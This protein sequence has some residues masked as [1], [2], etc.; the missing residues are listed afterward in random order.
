ME[1]HTYM[2]MPAFRELR[3]MRAENPKS[4]LP[5]LLGVKRLAKNKRAT[6]IQTWP[7]SNHTW[8][9]GCF[10]DTDRLNISTDEKERERF[11]K[12]LAKLTFG[13]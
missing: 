9:R 11:K 12:E 8:S 13:E 7:R 5:T 2:G 6:D 1:G 3:A 4:S 10:T